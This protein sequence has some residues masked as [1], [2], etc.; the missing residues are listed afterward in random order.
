MSSCLAP[1]CQNAATKHHSGCHY[2]TCITIG[3]SVFL[4]TT[5]YCEK[6]KCYCGRGMTNTR[7]SRWCGSDSCLCRGMRGGTKCRNLKSYS[8]GADQYCG[9]AVCSVDICREHLLRDSDILNSDRYC[10]N[11]TCSTRNCQQPTE[12][13]VNHCN[14]HRCTYMWRPDFHKPWVRCGYEKRAGSNYCRSHVTRPNAVTSGQHKKKKKSP[15]PPPGSGSNGGSSSTIWERRDDTSSH[16][17]RH[18]Y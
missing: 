13:H 4:E 10:H 14:T 6:H 5:G 17:R 1:N 15:T 12:T 7:S 8:S 16:H 18:K 3:C 11:H 2:H 9:T